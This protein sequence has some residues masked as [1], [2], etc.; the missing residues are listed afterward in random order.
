MEVDLVQALSPPTLRVIEELAHEG[1]LS[2]ADPVLVT[3]FNYEGIAARLREQLPVV[4]PQHVDDVERKIVAA[5]TKGTAGDGQQENGLQ[6]TRKPAGGGDAPNERTFTGSA[7]QYDHSI[8]GLIRHLGE[9][10]TVRTCPTSP[11]W[12]TSGPPAARTTLT[13]IK[14]GREEAQGEPRRSDGVGDVEALV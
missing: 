14:D 10:P 4:T 13:C 11:G 12:C 3:V 8:L 6:P 9:N 5:I 1:R 2:E 7:P